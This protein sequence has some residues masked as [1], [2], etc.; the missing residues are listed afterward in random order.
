M[1]GGGR[2]SAVSGFSRTEGWSK[3]EVPIRLHFCGRDEQACMDAEGDCEK[4]CIRLFTFRLV[5][6]GSQNRSLLR[7]ISSQSVALFT[8]MVLVDSIRP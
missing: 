4:F 6:K 7:G 1:L 2:T 8:K 5:L 3:F